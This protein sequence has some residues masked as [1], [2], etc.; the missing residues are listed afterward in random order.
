[1]FV[2]GCL[3]AIISPSHVPIQMDAYG[4]ALVSEKMTEKATFV[5]A[6]QTMLL[7]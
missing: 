2:L 6:A 7:N 3:F 5:G 4:Q 1:V